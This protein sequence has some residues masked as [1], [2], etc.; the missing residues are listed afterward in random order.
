MSEQEAEM[1]AEAEQEIEGLLGSMDLRSKLGQMLLGGFDGRTMTSAA[2]RLIAA[3]RTGGIVYFSRNVSSPEQLAALTRE[4]QEAA[5]ANGVPPLWI[6]IDQEGGMVARITEGVTLMPG[7]MAI[8]AAGSE[9]DAYRCAYISGRELRSLGVN[10][11]YAP[12]LDVNNNPANPVIGV[13]SFGESPERAASF[14]AAAIRGLQDAGVGATAK[15]FPGHGDT[16]VDS[17]LDLPTVQHDRER[18]DAVELVPFKRAV[19]EGVDA[20]MSAHIYF[21]A[22]EREKLP[23]TLSP[24]VLTGLLREELGFDGIITTD[25]MEMNAIAEHYGVAEASV[26]AVLAGAD[27]VL[28]SHRLDRQGAALNALENAVHGGRIDESRIDASVRRL[29]RMKWKRGVLTRGAARKLLGK[30]ERD[31]VPGSLSGSVAESAVEA[32][33]PA[34]LRDP[35]SLDTARRVSENSVTLVKNEQG[36]LPLR[37]ARTLAVTCSA[38]VTAFVDESIAGTRGLGHELAELGLDV[39]DEIVE[40]DEVGPNSDRLAEAAERADIEQIVVGTYN[41]RFNPA[42]AALVLRLIGLGKPLAV[43]ALRDPYD[44]LEFPEAPAY[45][46]VYESRPLALGSAAK[47]LLGRIPFRGRLPV[48]LGEKYPAGWGLRP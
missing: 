21:P 9:E 1:T 14:G 11:N 5:E 37:A 20:V 12:V 46:A 43:V 27:Q 31:D 10:L 16:D 25:C 15:H 29:L 48:S 30:K 35:E 18:M 23:V 22:L 40:A 24:S 26:L 8:A 36:I 42:Q 4:L 33:K 6:S 45:A 44:L 7:Q 47:A 28:V 41:A 32:S 2:M 38:N 39:V 3:Y 19:E 13:R 34:A 17:H